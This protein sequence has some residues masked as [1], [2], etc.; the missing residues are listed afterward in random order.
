MSDCIKRFI[1][2]IKFCLIL[3]IVAKI[4][5]NYTGSYKESL[6]LY[7]I[8]STELERNAKAFFLK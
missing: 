7:Y 1:S 8:L 5:V 3:R 2:Y 6:T 4:K